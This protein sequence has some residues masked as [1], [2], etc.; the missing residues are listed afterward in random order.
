MGKHWMSLTALGFLTAGVVFTLLWWGYGR[1][2]SS[3]SPK[4]QQLRRRLPFWRKFTA[5]KHD[6]SSASYELLRHYDEDRLEA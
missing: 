1:L 3:G 4:G 6:D 2:L 5:K